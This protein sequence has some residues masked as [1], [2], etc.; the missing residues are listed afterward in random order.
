VHK[1]PIIAVFIVAA[2]AVGAEAR[3]WYVLA[4]GSGNTPTIQSA[5]DSA[6]SSGDA[7]LIQTGVYHEGGIVV[8]GKSIMFI[9]YEGQVYLIAPS[10]GSGTC[11]TIRNATAFSI[12]G[13]ALRGFETAIA[14]ENA[15]GTIQ[16]ITVR[17]CN[18]GVT[19]SDPVSSPTI[20][21]SLV[22]SCGTGIEVRGGSVTLQNQTIVNCSTGA[23]FLG[24][25]ATFSRTIVYNCGTGVQ[26]SGGS[27]SLNCNDFFLNV[28]N[29]TG[30]PPGTNDFSLDPKFC[31]WKSTAGP[32]WLHDT[33]PC[34]TKV[35]P[36][37]EYVGAFNAPIAGCTGTAVERA[38]WGSI[39]SIYR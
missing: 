17:K 24:G 12:E 5:V 32:Y 29:Y 14:V 35:N 16:W 31:F 36:C 26:C 30:C 21:Y 7:I 3:N 23:V 27:A 10:A 8:D 4:N 18:R 28:S 19:I 25:S 34:L 39:K 20:W 33:S 38:T 6:A 2:V 37:A 22:D 11:F 15:S 1:T 9:Q 13:I